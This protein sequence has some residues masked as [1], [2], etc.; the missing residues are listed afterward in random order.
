GAAGFAGL[1][2]LIR[3][4]EF[5]LQVGLGSA[6]HVLVINTEGA[7]A[8]GVYEALVGESA[9]S[10]GTRQAAWMNAIEH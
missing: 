5:S 7:T 10:V 2:E 1:S 6:S 9:I 8:P 3:N 4:P